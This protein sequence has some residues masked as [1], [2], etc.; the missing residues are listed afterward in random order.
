LNPILEK[1]GIPADKR[2]PQPITNF[3]MEIQQDGDNFTII[4]TGNRG[5]RESKFTVGTTFETEMLMGT[6]TV[7]L[8]SCWEGNCMLLT[9]EKGAKLY[10]EVV[11]NQLVSTLIIG[12]DTAKLYFNKC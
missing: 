10:R 5:T 9:S 8:T 11:G 1:L 3:S 7:K 2:P 6:V 12:G 4:S